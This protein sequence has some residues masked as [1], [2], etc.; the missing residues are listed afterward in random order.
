MLTEP[1]FTIDEIVVRL[2]MGGLPSRLD[3]ALGGAIAASLRVRTCGCEPTVESV[4]AAKVGP[5]LLR[6]VI[7]HLIETRHLPQ[8]ESIEA[9]TA[10]REAREAELFAEIA[11]VLERAEFERLLGD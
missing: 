5:A 8:P 11:D 9:V 10:A 1:V 4:E 7:D 2:V 6:A 3:R